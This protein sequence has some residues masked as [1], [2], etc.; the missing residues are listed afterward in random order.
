MARK[1]TPIAIPEDAVYVDDLS[2]KI[3]LWRDEYGG[4]RQVSVM[5]VV[6][7]A[8]G[9]LLIKGAGS[10]ST[11]VLAAA[12][13]LGDGWLFNTVDI[14]DDTDDDEEEF[15]AQVAEEAPRKATTTRQ[16]RGRAAQ[17]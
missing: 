11:E 14:A 4:R 9:D 13:Q 6:T 1:Y 8:D 12:A 5:R 15:E 10:L 16:R 7:K 17:R 3:A 2:S